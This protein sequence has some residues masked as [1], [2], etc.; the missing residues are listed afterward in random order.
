MN[1]WREEHAAFTKAV[2]ETYAL[3]IK[4]YS[5]IVLFPVFWVSF[6]TPSEP[7]LFERALQQFLVHS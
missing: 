3:D 6:L 5:H 1:P 4:S 2:L 7:R